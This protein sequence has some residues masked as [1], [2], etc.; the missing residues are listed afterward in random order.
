MRR[1]FAVL[2]LLAACASKTP[3]PAAPTPAP[4][5][6]EDSAPTGEPKNTACVE[7]CTRR[8]Q[9]RAVAAEQIV[10]DCE[11]QCEDVSPP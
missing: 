4:A 7:E 9:M 8:N 3:E 11:R 5:S 2:M 6:S 1:A 10:R